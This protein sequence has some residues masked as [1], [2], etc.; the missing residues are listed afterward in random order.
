MGRR[1]FSGDGSSACALAGNSQWNST[2]RLFH[3]FSSGFA[4]SQIPLAGLGMAPDVLDW[5]ATRPSGAVYPD[6]GAGI[7]GMEAASRGEYR[8]GFARGGARVE[9]FRLSR[10]AHVLHDV[11]L[12]RNAGSLSRFP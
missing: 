9:A 5:R 12:A 3:R 6:E 8:T 10:G 4:R 2:E 11:P 7:G 1:S